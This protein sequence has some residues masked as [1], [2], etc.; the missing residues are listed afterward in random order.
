MV[1]NCVYQRPHQALRKYGTKELGGRVA[2]GKR[3]GRIPHTAS[4]SMLR[5]LD[6]RRINSIIEQQRCLSLPRK[7]I[8]DDRNWE[9]NMLL[10]KGSL[11]WFCNMTEV[12]RAHDR[13]ME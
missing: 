3:K 9:Q 4:K 11:R 7:M 10:C 6:P 8:L 5:E 12:Y 1:N 13:T 2:L